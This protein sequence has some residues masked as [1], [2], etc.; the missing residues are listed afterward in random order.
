MKQT[1]LQWR[2]ERNL[3][4]NQVAARAGVSHRILYQMEHGRAVEPENADKV[5][6]VLG[7]TREQV[8]GLVL[9]L[10]RAQRV[11]HGWV[12]NVARK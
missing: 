1:I 9:A 11:N 5:L 7:V 12:R 6:A 8:E 10:P 4:Q 2:A 3:T